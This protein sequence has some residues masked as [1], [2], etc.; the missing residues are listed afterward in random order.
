MALLTAPG[1]PAALLQR[2]RLLGP[3]FVAA[4]AYV[5]PGNVATNTAAGA[6]YRYL[7]LWV[8]VGATLMAGLVQYLSAKVGWLTGESLPALVGQRTSRRVRLAY[9]AQAELVAA[10]TDV[11]EIVGG[12]IALQLLFGL[13]LLAGALVTAAVSTAV[14]YVQRHGQVSFERVVV[15]LLAVVTAGFLA[16]L[17]VAPPDPAEA[18][19]GLVPRLA[20]TD[21]ALLAVG[22]LGATV[23]P[24]AVYLHSALV[25]DRHG[26]ATAVSA[27]R[28]LTAVKVDVGL[29]MVVAGSVNIAMLLLS[30]SALHGLSLHGLPEVHAALA[31]HLGRVVATCFALAL[32]ASGL[33]S[34]SVGG[35]AGAVVMDGLLNR[36]VP[37]LA[38]RLVTTVPALV[39]L[40]TGLDPTRLLILSQVVLSFGIPFALVP[41]VRIARDRRLM[42]LVPTHRVTLALA[43]VV[44]GVIVVLNVVLVVLLVAG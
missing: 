40:A 17:A 28:V 23:M 22:M 1:R 31:G 24:H 16:G 41:L 13:P 10:A 5:D 4:V 34:T 29:A 26:R 12:A 27:R 39:L 19:T 44:T 9:W 18:V 38:R 11:A 21:S 20:G 36:R 6:S 8:L 32:L 37:L 2:T 7:L 30:G 42:A 14:L 3:A 43:W 35:Y 33:A 25:R 15:G